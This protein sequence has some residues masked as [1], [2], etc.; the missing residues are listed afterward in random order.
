VLHRVFRSRIASAQLEAEV[1][2][3]TC[4][5][6]HPGL[7]SFARARVDREDVARHTLRS[8]QASPATSPRAPTS[9]RST[10]R[11]HHSSLNRG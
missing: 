9:T 6:S 10:D 11:T 5:D 1:R 8:A 2:L 7:V 4:Q 3:A